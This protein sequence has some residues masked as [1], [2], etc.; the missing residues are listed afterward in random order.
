MR[1]IVYVFW[2][3]I[4][5]LGVTFAS[6]NPQKLLINYYIDTSTV[7]LPLLLL[8]TLVVGAFLGVIAMLPTVIRSKSCNRRLKH[9]V[10][11]I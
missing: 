11:Q 2:I 8:V 1:Y 9:Q 6:L 3:I 5:L 7:H 4:I 10:K